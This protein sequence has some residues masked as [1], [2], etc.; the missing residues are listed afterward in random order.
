MSAPSAPA[1]GPP[2]SA[3]PARAL[4]LST[5]VRAS[6]LFLA[7]AVLVTGV[8]YPVGL[9]G[10][11]HLLDRGSAGGSLLRCPNGTVVG[12]ADVAQNL[13]GGTLGPGLFW[14]RPSLTDYNTTLG[15]ASPP[16]PSDPALA[17]LFNETIAY[18]RSYGNLTVNATVPYWYA[19]PSASS[20]DPDLVPEAVL[21]QVLR[22]AAN[23]HLNVTLVTGL[24][25]EHILHP[26][27]PFV[28][29]DYVDVLELDLA[30]L[31]MTGGC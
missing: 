5:H 15:A 19:S 3:P 8:A 28:G 7:L 26:V 14:A 12:S 20:T 25:N 23:D 1:A 2:A 16:G 11:A 10:V 18:M 30:L 9:S 17:R 22:V 6:V 21:V 27:V 13:T 29:T 31:A 4:R 24:V